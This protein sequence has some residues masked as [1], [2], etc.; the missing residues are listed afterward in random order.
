MSKTLS[1]ATLV[2]DFFKH[3]KYYI[4]TYILNIQNSFFHVFL[5]TELFDSD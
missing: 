1:L 5:D 3:I 4:S 2:V